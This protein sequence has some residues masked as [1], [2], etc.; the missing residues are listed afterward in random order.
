[1]YELS[2]IIPETG[3]LS[4]F[5]S[6]AETVG[7]NMQSIEILVPNGSW[8]L[9]IGLLENSNH[10]LHQLGK[11]SAVLIA[12]LL[13]VFTRRIV[14]EPE[15]LRKQVLAQTQ[16]LHRLAYVDSLT[17]LPNRHRFTEMLRDGIQQCPTSDNCLALLLMDLDHFKE[18]NDTLGHEVGDILLRDAGNRLTKILPEGATLARLGG[19]EFTVVVVGED[20]A[21]VA[22]G[23]ARDIIKAIEQPFDLNGNIAHISVSIGIASASECK[24]LPGGELLKCADQAM[25]EVKRTGRGGFIH[26]TESIQQKIALRSSL[27]NDLRKATEAGQLHL[28]YQPIIS[29]DSGEVEK[30]EA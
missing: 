16:D 20:I 22:K 21:E 8:T 29:S 9:K 7:V 5:A 14:D 6:N 1:M 23:I 24:D 10:T 12:I 18:V 3:S 28:L 30:A 15:T 27:A 4:I 17:G 19:D 13:A 11:L 2:R 26:Y 25:Y